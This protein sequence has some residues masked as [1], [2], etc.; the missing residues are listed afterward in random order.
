MLAILSNPLFQPHD[1]MHRAALYPGS[2][3][4]VSAGEDATTHVRLFRVDM[5]VKSHA[6]LTVGKP[7]IL[8]HGATAFAPLTGAP[9]TNANPI[10]IVGIAPQT[11]AGAEMT[12]LS[13]Y[14]Y[15]AHA[16]QNNSAAAGDMVEV[17]TTGTYLIDEGAAVF[18]PG[19][20]GMAL[21]AGAGGASS[22]AAT[23]TWLFGRPLVIAAA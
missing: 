6:A 12:W 16:L 1:F 8:T 7:Y 21:E 13:L 18:G 20:V 10:N 17:L 9:L 5:R 23:K 3:R 4:V 2:C 14:G 22:G 19:S 15:S 11:T